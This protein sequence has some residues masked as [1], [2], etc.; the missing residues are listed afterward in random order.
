LSRTAKVAS[1]WQVTDP[2]EPWDP[3]TCL[4]CR[5]EFALPGLPVGARCEPEYANRRRLR[6]VIDLLADGW[7]LD[8]LRSHRSLQSRE[9]QEAVREVEGRWRAAPPPTS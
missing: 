1:P 3:S 4:L 2:T 7:S 5:A 8:D 6:S 9:S